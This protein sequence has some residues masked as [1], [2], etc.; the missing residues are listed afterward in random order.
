MRE[1]SININLNSDVEQLMNKTEALLLCQATGAVTL[2]T[3][4]EAMKADNDVSTVTRF[5]Q[6]PAHCTMSK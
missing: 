4:Y 3:K 6:E 5:G 2:T 1:G